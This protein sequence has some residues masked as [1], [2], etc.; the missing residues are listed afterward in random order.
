MRR[1]FILSGLIFILFVS[2]PVYALFG[3]VVHLNPYY[4]ICYKL[5]GS[6]Y[7]FKID[8]TTPEGWTCGD[9]EITNNFL[10]LKCGSSKYGSAFKGIFNG[11]DG[12]KA[13][14]S[15]LFYDTWYGAVY[16]YGPDGFSWIEPPLNPVNYPLIRSISNY[17]QGFNL[18]TYPDQIE[19]NLNP[20]PP[21]IIKSISSTNGSTLKSKT[22]T[23]TITTDIN[24]T[25]KYSNVQG[26]NFSNMTDFTDTNSTSHSF[27]FEG[28]DSTNYSFYIKC[29][30]EFGD[31]SPDD[32]YLQFFVDYNNPPNITSTPITNGTEGTSYTY[33]VIA[34][35]PDNNPLWYSDNTTLFN[36]NPLTGSIS[37]IPTV[38]G[39]YTI[40]ITVSD[41]IETSSQVY[42]LSIELVN[43]A[44]IIEPIGTLTAIVNQPFTNQISAND[45][46]GDGLKFS[47]GTPLFDINETTG[48][49]NFTPL[50]N[51]T[52]KFN[53][54]VKDNNSVNP[55]NTTEIGWLIILNENV[56]NTAPNITSYSPNSSTI[57]IN[58]MNNTI[59]IITK[60]DPDGAP[61]VQWY[62]N[63]V[64]I[65]GANSDNY[66]FVSN[67]KIANSSAG[68]YDIKVVVSDGILTDMRSWKLIVD[69]VKDSDNDGISDDLFNSIC[70][71]GNNNNCND[72][73]K[74]IPNYD[75]ADSDNDTI[76]DS[77]ENDYDGDNV[78]DNLD[79]IKGTIGVIDTN[80]NLELKINNSDNLNRVV[81][82]T[83]IVEFLFSATGK[84]LVS[85]EYNFS[86]NS[87]LDLA[88]I[89]IKPEN[90]S[91]NGSILI[92]GI[93]SSKNVI[94]NHINPS[95]N[96]VCIKNAE[97]DFIANISNN[98]NE[99]NEIIITCDGTLQSGYTC[100][101]LGGTYNITGLTNSGV[102]E[103][104]ATK[105]ET[106][107][108]PP[109][110]GSSSGSSGGGSS[111]G[112]GG[113][114][115]GGGAGFIC[116][117]D[118][119]CGEW[120]ECINGLRTRQCD[121]VK[122]TQHWQETPCPIQSNAPITA[123]K[124]ESKQ[125]TKP[126]PLKPSEIKGIT[127]AEFISPKP[128][129]QIANNSKLSTKKESNA[130]TGAIIANLKP[131]YI[132]SSILSLVVIVSILLIYK[133]FK[134][135]RA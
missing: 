114:G 33:N 14:R 82:G 126:T 112:G 58:E 108:T 35:D 67:N 88:K 90:V 60:T 8:R 39:D 51:G 106:P 26:L 95:T 18:P 116:N 22:N 124:C 131:S 122:V 7:N 89:I 27:S 80:I 20:C 75:Q 83:N 48:I 102:I 135:L 1:P 77:C 36:I 119:K 101:D 55:K 118:W 96:R 73:C 43:H 31:V 41:G 85:F 69:R 111:G 133:K 79:F 40:K 113:G 72:N 74:F 44:P 42:N 121:F 134:L 30:D 54:N 50:V 130:I 120:S 132:V 100:T 103:T 97:I 28:R 78:S 19:I 17:W 57:I 34:T 45:P 107:S 128:N 13:C 21:A 2:L 98:C 49:I 6:T 81:N 71:G 68:I 99:S 3:R 56:T 66:T 23:I 15:Y 61:L 87:I 94:M 109:S 37:F 84:T 76:G 93:N 105:Q 91:G 9:V 104:L 25:C 86:N 11:C 10:R 110:S 64:A 127:T 4:H 47:D 16:S 38:G 12:G 46:D 129:Q 62:K 125:E 5:S 59:F 63:N 29:N 65:K 92:K 115:G 53:I 70:V 52:Y 32:N 117:M 123:Q 24:A